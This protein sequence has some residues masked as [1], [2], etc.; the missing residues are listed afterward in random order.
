MHEDND[1]CSDVVVQL[2][3][4]LGNRIFQLALGLACAHERPDL[5]VGYLHHDQVG[6]V[7][8]GWAGGFL[9]STSG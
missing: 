6:G 7:W 8:C 5:N 1:E 2:S 4:G 9:S 3:G